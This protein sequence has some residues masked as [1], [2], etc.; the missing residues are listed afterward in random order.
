ML[1][2]LVFFD[3]RL[4]NGQ[5]VRCATCHVPER[6][7]ADGK[8]V[9]TGLRDVTRNS[10]SLLSAA[11][12]HWQTWD[13]KADTI[14][15]QPIIAFE[16]PRE[17]DFT[18]LELA[19][20]IV[21]LY[22]PKYEALFGPLPDLS[23]AQRFPPRG[24]PGDAAWQAMT[25]DDRQ[26]IDRITSNVGKAIEAY[27]RKLAMRPGKLDAFLDGDDTALSATAVK[28]LVVFM[29]IGCADCHS[30]PMLSDGAFHRFELPPIP[31]EPV[32]HG[33]R[34]GLAYLAASDFNASS[35]FFDGEKEPV[36]TATADDDFAWRTAP[37]RNVARTAPYGHDGSFATVEA[38]TDFHLPAGVSAA[39]RA[40]L[41]EFLAALN[42]SDPP[43][44]WNNWPNR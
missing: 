21:D 24:R 9:S 15:S 18:R 25:P 14:W 17:M 31:N 2:H 40:A 26:V 42:A 33:R 20:A 32:E 11:F 5:M 23:D 10:P 3:A 1:G 37:L 22:K 19:H 8:A 34:D 28:G 27:V 13:G 16:N 12:L 36:P 35:V 44:P 41:L 38:V 39:D 43:S 7:F 4:S 6:Y 29:K 30:G